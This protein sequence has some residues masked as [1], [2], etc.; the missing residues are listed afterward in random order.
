MAG[1]RVKD[2]GSST[3]HYSG[4]GVP[5]ESLRSGMERTPSIEKP[6]LENPIQH[7]S[8]KEAARLD[9]WLEE[10]TFNERGNSFRD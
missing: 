9:G 3:H 6:A 2:G 8:S 10:L 5:G 4:Q 1:R 7:I